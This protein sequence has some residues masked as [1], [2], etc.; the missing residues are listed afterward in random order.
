VTTRALSTHAVSGLAVS[1]DAP[2]SADTIERA[3]SPR[4]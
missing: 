3:V 2:A 4:S 1:I